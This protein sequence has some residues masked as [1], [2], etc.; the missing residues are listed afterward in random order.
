MQAV[1]FI[2]ILEKTFSHGLKCMMNQDFN[3]S[4]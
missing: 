2:L 1:L 4:D 3:V